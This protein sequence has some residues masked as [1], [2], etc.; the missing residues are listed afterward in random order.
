MGRK[1]IADRLYFSDC[2]RFAELINV[3]LYHGEE[4]L[5]PGNLSLLRR[6]YPSLSSAC[7][8]LERS[9][10]WEKAIGRADAD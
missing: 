3:V 5:L 7:G 9:F 2:R 1:D 8:E 10:I 4:V 6:K